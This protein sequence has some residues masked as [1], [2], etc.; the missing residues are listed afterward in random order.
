MVK[1]LSIAK[2]HTHSRVGFVLEDLVQCC[3]QRITIGMAPAWTDILRPLVPDAPRGYNA[4]GV[5]FEPRF[6]VKFRNGV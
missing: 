1:H 5:A 4:I 2:R 3:G 6:I